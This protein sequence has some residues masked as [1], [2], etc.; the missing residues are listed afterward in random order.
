MTDH[1]ADAYTMFGH[2]LVIRGAGFIG[3]H[4]ADQ[5]VDGCAVTVYDDLSTDSQDNIPGNFVFIHA[6]VRDDEPFCDAV[7]AADVVFHGAARVS[8]QWSV[9]DSETIHA[10]NITPSLTILEAAQ[11]ADT[12]VIFASSAAI[13]SHPQSLSVDESYPKSPTLA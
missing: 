1:L 13:Y 9:D 8:I 6:D 4:L 7:R 5:P 11:N 2:A 3:S 12:R 10:V